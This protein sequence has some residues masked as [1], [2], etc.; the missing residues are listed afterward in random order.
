MTHLIFMFPGQG[1]QFVEMGKDL[2][3]NF[4]EIQE[5][6]QEASDTLGFDMKKLC[7][8]DPKHQL[9]LTEFTQPA[10]LTLSVAT[11]HVLQNHGGLKPHLVAGH[12]LGE[13]SA[14]VAAQALSFSDALKAVQFR[15]QAM[16]KAVPIGTGAMA[17]YLGGSAQ[18]VFEICEHIS[19]ERTK[20]EGFTHTG[21]TERVEVVNFNAPQQLVLSGHK[22]AVARAC[23]LIAMQKLGKAKELPVSAPFHSTLMEPAA[24]EMAAFLEHI[25]FKENKYEIVANVDANIYLKPSYTKQLLIKQIAHPVRWTQSLLTIHA[26]YPNAFWIELGPGKVLQGLAKKTIANAQCLG[27]QDCFALKNVLQTF[28]K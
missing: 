9:N 26:K 4:F 3:E 17:A 20:T 23:E 28:E 24:K 13:Y 12:S 7:F 27:T 19:S 2:F 1:S 10:L 5:H 14:L 25:P 11:Y 18:E 22:N 21:I 8:E 6:F 16:Q 15:G